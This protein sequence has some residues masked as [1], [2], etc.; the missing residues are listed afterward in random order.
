MC[1]LCC[2]G[3][4]CVIAGYGYKLLILDGITVSSLTRLCYYVVV[5]TLIVA[6]LLSYYTPV[7]IQL[8]VIYCDIATCWILLCSVLVLGICIDTTYT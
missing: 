8:L 5:S 7:D 6:L 2:G 3:V 1:A 4:V